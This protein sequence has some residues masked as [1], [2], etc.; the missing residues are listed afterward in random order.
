MF[1]IIRA[2][3]IQYAADTWKIERKEAYEYVANELCVNNEAITQQRE[4]KRREEQQVI[5]AS[6][7]RTND[8]TAYLF[9]FFALLAQ[10]MELQM[11]YVTYSTY[12]R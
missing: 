8:L 5:V 3:P 6:N 1:L 2:L 12:A 7:K 9:F 11:D 10:N 4:E